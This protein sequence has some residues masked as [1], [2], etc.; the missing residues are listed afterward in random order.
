MHAAIYD[1]P[2]PSRVARAGAPAVD[3]RFAGCRCYFQLLSPAR[4][5]AHFSD[6]L[7]VFSTGARAE[8]DT[9]AWH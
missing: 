6:G 4:R 7:L 1:K 2:A 9:A 5:A 8:V 3:F